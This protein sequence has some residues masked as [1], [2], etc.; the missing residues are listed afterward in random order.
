ML[1]LLG[2]LSMYSDR[3]RRKCSSA[4]YKTTMTNLTSAVTRDA[5]V[6]ERFFVCEQNFANHWHEII[7]IVRLGRSCTTVEYIRMEWEGGGEGGGGSKEPMYV[8]LL[9]STQSCHP[10]GVQNTKQLK[11]L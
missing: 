9:K 4:L 6:N 1:L 5:F 10:E 8:G 11:A 3:P 2:S 7:L